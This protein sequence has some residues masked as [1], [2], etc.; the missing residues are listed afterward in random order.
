M[1]KSDIKKLLKAVDNKELSAV[2]IYIEDG[3]Y[4]I[5]EVEFEIDWDEHQRM[6]VS[7]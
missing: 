3:G 1:P 6:I 4:R 7:Y 2:G 5:A